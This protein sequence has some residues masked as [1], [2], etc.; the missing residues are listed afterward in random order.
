VNPRLVALRIL[1]QVIVDGK[2]LNQCAAQ[3]NEQIDDVKDRALARE[4][5]FGVLRYYFQLSF[6]LNHLLE[7]PLKAK[8][9]DIS[10]LLMMGIY[11]LRFMRIPDHAA[12][13][14][15][16]K[17][18]QKL[19]KKWA[20]GFANGVLRSC[21]RETEQLNE[22]IEAQEEAKYAHPKWLLGKM[23]KD[24]PEAWQNI[25]N[26]N[27][28]HAPMVLRVNQQKVY[29]DE[30]VQQLAALEITGSS[31]L[32]VKN[33]VVLEQA[34]DVSLLPG[35]YQGVVSV[36]D[37]AAQQAADLL[38]L[39]KKCYVLD[40][41]AAPGGKTAH[42]IETEPEAEVLALELSHKRLELISDT[43]ARLQLKAEVKCADASVVDE[44]WDGRQFDRILLDAPC[45]ATGVIRRNPDIKVHRTFDDINAV[46]ETQAKLLDQLW[47]LL[48]PG[49]ILLY[50]TCSIIKNE[51]ENQIQHFID[52]HDDATEKELN[53]SWGR[54]CKVGVQLLPGDHQ[55]DGFYYAKI[56]KSH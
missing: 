20:K 11:Q 5:V 51:N 39:T 33:G 44:W 24:W 6:V 32:D 2:S 55:M 19:K 52:T 7:K 35:F 47:P 31:M 56:I 22:L 54:K 49:G 46:V 42:I 14:E 38:E 3:I 41:C 4:I 26:Q 29:V 28:L 48:K 36:Q 34:C 16:V 40:A 23:Q 43:L 8:D 18:T 17:L 21:L 9:I 45:S 10:C 15:S 12:V 37:A 50:A 25:A 13:N 1:V 30:Y 53:V 27:N